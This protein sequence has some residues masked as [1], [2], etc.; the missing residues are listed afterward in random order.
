MRTGPVLAELHEAAQRSI[1]H[2]QFRRDYGWVR[3]ASGFAM[4]F[5][6]IDDQRAA[7]SAFALLGNLS[8]DHPWEF[9]RGDIATNVRQRRAR[10]LAAAGGA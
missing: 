2:P 4:I 10:A 1:W 6:L 8:A 9:L 3:V 7:A 5:G